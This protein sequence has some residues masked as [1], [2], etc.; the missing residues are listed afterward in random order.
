MICRWD[1]IKDFVFGLTALGDAGDFKMCEVHWTGQT[2][3]FTQVST[4]FSKSNTWLFK[5]T[6][7]HLTST[8]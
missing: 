4:F 3:H 6:R 5:P 8:Q 7:V 1:E 2:G